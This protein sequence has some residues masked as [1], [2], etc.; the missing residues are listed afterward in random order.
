[1]KN[2][3]GEY[4]NELSV[5]LFDNPYVKPK[6]KYFMTVFGETKWIL[7]LVASIPLEDKDS[8]SSSEVFFTPPPGTRPS[9]KMYFFHEIDRS[10][11]LDI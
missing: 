1:M 11:V 6:P 2:E 5:T 10:S 8:A 9:Q 4:R 7:Y 3:M